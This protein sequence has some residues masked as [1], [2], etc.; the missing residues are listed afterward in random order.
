MVSPSPPQ[1]A[2]S[3]SK[4][5]RSLH[6]SHSLFEAAMASLRSPSHGLTHVDPGLTLLD[7]DS[8]VVGGLFHS[9]GEGLGMPMHSPSASLSPLWTIV[10]LSSGSG[11]IYAFD[12]NAEKSTLQMGRAPDCDIRIESQ[13]VSRKHALISK[14]NDGTVR[15]FS[16]FHALL[17]LW[18]FTPTHSLTQPQTSRNSYTNSCGSQRSR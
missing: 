4:A 16:P 2:L 1:G 18:A 15:P 10:P 17:S 11:D 7:P 3:T 14:K 8:H 6:F 13:A 9:G 12:D 5:L